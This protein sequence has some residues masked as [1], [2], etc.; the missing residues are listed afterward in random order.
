MPV[1]APAAVGG[2][3]AGGAGRPSTR[4]SGTCS[5]ASIARRSTRSPSS[6]PAEAAAIGSLRTPSLIRG[7]VLYDGQAIADSIPT[8]GELSELDQPE[9]RRGA[10]PARARPHARGADR[11]RDRAAAEADRSPGGDGGAHLLLGGAP[12][13]LRWTPASTASTCRAATAAT[14]STRRPTCASCIELSRG[15]VS[16]GWCAAL[17]SAHALQIASW[18]EER[19]QA[20]IF[21]DGDFRAASVAAPIGTADPRRRRLGAEREGRLLL[22]ASRTPRTTWARR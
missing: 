20:E 8:H 16:T 12:S 17:A 9:G 15:C 21:G 19:A 10:K 5:S 18:F 22:R 4:V 11:A 13:G 14:S 2:G 6:P 7:R 3:A 1:G